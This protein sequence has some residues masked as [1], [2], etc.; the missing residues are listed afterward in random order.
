MWCTLFFLYNI[1]TKKKKLS[2]ASQVAAFHLVVLI[3]GLLGSPEKLCYLQHTLREKLDPEEKTLFIYRSNSNQGYF[4]TTDG[5]DAGGKRLYTEIKELINAHSSFKYISFV[6]ISLGGLYARYTIGEMYDKET[7]TL[8]GLIPLNFVTFATPHLGIRGQTHWM[9]ETTFSWFSIRTI[10]QLFIKDGEK[11]LISMTQPASKWM[12]GLQLFSNHTTYANMQRD[13]M[14]PYC[15]ASIYPLILNYDEDSL[16]V[17]P[18][19]HVIKVH[20]DNKVLDLEDFF[21]GKQAYNLAS[22]EMKMVLNL[23][24]DIEWMRIDC[25]FDGFTSYFFS[26]SHIYVARQWLNSDGADV[27]EHFVSNFCIK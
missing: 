25:L 9:I 13:L 4:S 2:M 15:T 10:E 7:K 19:N 8:L 12:E 6:G 23:R 3:N 5:I 11:L 18:H 27:V 20:R 22:E 14:V 16:S 21:K 17:N 24:N 26:H 1:I